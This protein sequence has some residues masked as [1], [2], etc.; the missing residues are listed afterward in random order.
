M[1]ALDSEDR[2]CDAALVDLRRALVYTASQEVQEE[3][4]SSLPLGNVVMLGEQP[5]TESKLQNPATVLATGLQAL[6]SAKPVRSRSGVFRSATE[7]CQSVVQI[8][9]QKKRTMSL[10]VH[11]L[12]TSDSLSIVDTVMNQPKTGGTATG[13]D[14]TSAATRAIPTNLL[15]AEQA[16][17]EFDIA[18]SIWGPN[19]STTRFERWARRMKLP[20]P[21]TGW[22]WVKDIL[23]VFPTLG[24]LRA[25][26][27]C[28]NCT[29]QNPLP[30]SGSPLSGWCC[31]RPPTQNRKPESTTSSHHTFATKLPRVGNRS[32]CLAN[33]HTT[34]PS[35]NDQP[36]FPHTL[37]NVGNTCFFN[38]A[39]QVIA[40]L[41]PLVESIM[42]TPAPQ[43]HSDETYCLVLLQLFLPEI[44]ALSPEPNTK[45]I[46]S[47][48]QSG[49]RYMNDTDW[50][51]FVDRLTRYDPAYSPGKMA[52]PGDLINYILSL[53][54][55]AASLCE[56]HVREITTFRCTCPGGCY[57][58]NMVAELGLTIQ[59]IS[60]EPLA[61]QIINTF[62]P[63][64]VSDYRCDRCRKLANSECPAIRTRHLH[65]FPQTLR[66][67]ITASLA[68]NALPRD[69]HQYPLQRFEY[70]EL[71]PRDHFILKAAVNYNRQ[72]YWVYVHGRFPI[73]IDDERSR[74]ATPDD[75][76]K[77]AKSARILFY[78]RQPGPN[79]M[80]PA[81]SSSIPSAT[82]R[83]K[84]AGATTAEMPFGKEGENVSKL[85]ESLPASAPP[86]VRQHTNLPSCQDNLYPTGSLL[87]GRQR[88]LADFFTPQLKA[89]FLENSPAQPQRPKQT[90][91]G[92]CPDRH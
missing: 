70:L 88:T 3:L 85:A 49:G 6:V 77:V 39:L 92:H 7:C 47:S 20:A 10:T 87:T 19:L 55:G 37:R 84:R 5:D 54:S 73:V 43:D 42:L 59:N 66:I 9:D 75:Y 13:R 35:R 71:S 23:R 56:V 41:H 18:K 62:K 25:D 14:L 63:D 40:S 53:A 80:D 51:D 28:P 17:R 90:I 22:D 68:E 26:Q 72:H 48:V 31:M 83:K 78:E 82:Q 44:A 21:P 34:K 86:A 60:D 65:S 91:T 16:L 81:A 58:E 30:L 4:T 67:N 1:A 29:Q 74:T 36:L 12:N 32:P 38:S 8:P 89:V 64:P 24:S 52:D 45:L 69:S 61:K 50:N 15:D 33:R 46:V 2:S 27:R 57:T 11:E 76:Q 79:L